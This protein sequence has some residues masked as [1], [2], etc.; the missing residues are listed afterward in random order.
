MALFNC[1]SRA[2]QDVVAILRLQWG[3]VERGP[4]QYL[5]TGYKQLLEAIRQTGLKLQ[6]SWSKFRVCCQLVLG[7][8]SVVHGMIHDESLSSSTLHHQIVFSFHA[9]GD[10]VGDTA[11]VPLPAWVLRCGDNDPDIFFTDR[12]R[13]GSSGQRNREY[14]SIWA[15]EAAALCGRSPIQCY[16]DFMASFRESFSQVRMEPR[17]ER[18]ALACMLSG[19][20]CPAGPGLHSGRSCRGCWAM[21][22]AAL[23]ELCRGQRLEVS[24]CW[25]V[26]GGCHHLS[27]SPL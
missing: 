26:P 7:C 16:E 5:W 17:K 13:G 12:P 18:D 1:M 6:V 23:P 2:L 11:H 25:R 19:A 21:R 22:R 4:G 8:V 20:C 9:C 10:N 14:L 27:S 3:A 24:W 15:D